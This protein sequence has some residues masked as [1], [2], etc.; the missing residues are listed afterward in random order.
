MSCPDSADW[1]TPAADRAYVCAGGG[2]G[3][4]ESSRRLAR[5]NAFLGAIRRVGFVDQH[6]TPMTYLLRESP[7]ARAVPRDRVLLFDLAR[8]DTVARALARH[9]GQT[10]APVGQRMS[11]QH[12]P[13]RAGGKPPPGT[14][15]WQ[16][17][18]DELKSSDDPLAAQAM[19]ALCDLYKED[20]S[21]L[22]SFNVP[23]CGAARECMGSGGITA[24]NAPDD[25]L[26]WVPTRE[27]SQ[28]K[29]ELNK[30][31]GVVFNDN[32]CAMAKVDPAKH[33][34]H[35]LVTRLGENWGAFSSA[36]PNRTAEWGDMREHWANEGCNM[37]DI[38]GYLD[39]EHVKMVVTTQHHSALDHPK[40]VSLPLGVRQGGLLLRGARPQP[41]R[42]AAGGVA[43]ARTPARTQWLMINDSGF[44]H[45]KAIAE[46]VVRNMPP[47]TV[48]NTYDASPGADRLAYIDEMRRSRFVL[49]PSGMGVD[50]FRVWQALYL[51][52][53][54]V[55]EKATAFGWDRTLDDLPVLW[56]TDFGEVNQAL[57]EAAYPALEAACAHGLLRWEKLTRSWWIRRVLDAAGSDV[58]SGSSSPTAH[59]NYARVPGTYNTDFEIDHTRRRRRQ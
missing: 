19:E 55:V 30:S 34:D 40:I 53:V 37:A 26:E 50:S 38:K 29:T 21:C 7:V 48:R 56:V 22:Q 18:L 39:N 49:C 41:G 44:R 28:L 25:M 51:G 5:L 12:G 52:A 54:P 24:A 31:S 1:G 13:T 43:R 4:S 57:L 14:M 17:T 6:V 35:V 2:G 8:F 23:E 36:I 59:A 16:I 15:S 3:A 33:V 42:H 47:G 11:R 20:V 32:V 10:Y 27:F 46:R 45:R 58:L 9:V